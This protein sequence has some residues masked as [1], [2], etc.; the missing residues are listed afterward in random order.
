MLKREN[1]QMQQV[2]PSFA[3]DPAPT[4]LQ[5]ANLTVDSARN[6]RPPRRACGHA[7][8]IGTCP[9]CQ[10]VQLAKWDTQL[11][12]ASGFESHR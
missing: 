2:T 6:G 7:R 12:Q 4:R 5:T 11:A 8:H 1:R 10:R 9:C 3:R